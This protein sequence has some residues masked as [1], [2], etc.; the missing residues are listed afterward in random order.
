MN[1]KSDATIVKQPFNMDLFLKNQVDAAAAMTYNE[2]AKVLETK[3]PKTGQLYKPSDLNIISMESVGTGMLEDG[4]FVRGDWISNKD[5]QETAKKF[6]AAS[7]KGSVYCRDPGNECTQI[8]LNNGSTLGQGHQTWQMNEINALTWPA[9]N[10]IGVM[11]KAA[12]GRTAKIAQD[13]KVI[14]KAPSPDAYRTDL[15]QDAVDEIS[16]EGVDVNG[17]DYKKVTVTGTPRGS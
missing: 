12:F 9:P 8:V 17:N 14:K 1:P 15:A 5:N 3:N 6:L 10:G 13:F 7:F 4:V 16:A 2:L 11:D